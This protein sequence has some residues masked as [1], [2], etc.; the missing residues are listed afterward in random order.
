MWE[1]IRDNIKVSNKARFLPSKI[2]K[3]NLEICDNTDMANAYNEFFVNIG[4]S[5]EKKIPDS[6]N[7]FSFY[8]K[9]K[10][11]NSISLTEIT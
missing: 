4:D 6:K 3:N 2:M 1:G 10:V 7:E 8:L 5:V 9:K 11:K